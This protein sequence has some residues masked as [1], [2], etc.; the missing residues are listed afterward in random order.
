[1]EAKKCLLAAVCAGMLWCL[2]GSDQAAGGDQA[3][4]ADASSTGVGVVECKDVEIRAKI[5]GYITEINVEEGQTVAVGEPL[6]ATDPRDLEVK[7]L[8]AEASVKGAQAQLEKARNG[9]RSQEV[10]A[11]KA[12]ADK[13]QANVDLLQTQYDKMQQMYEAG[14][15]SP[16]TMDQLTTQLEAAKL[17]LEAA[18][19]Q[20]NMA[21]AGARQEDI[22]AL[23]AQ[24]EAAQ[25]TLAEVQLNLDETRVTAPAAGT[26]TMISS[27]V[28]ELI[29]SGTPV[30]TLTDYSDSWVT[31]NVSELQIAQVQLN[32]TVTI[33]SKA[34][35][36]Q[37]FTG[38]VVNVNKNPDFATKK[39]TNELNDQD[40]VSYEVKVKLP[41]DTATLYPGMLVDVTFPKA[42]E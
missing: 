10:D 7:K 24:Y 35:P 31:V 2:W 20:Y 18:S 21:A 15:L 36:D 34:Y 42:G 12:L 14:A 22:K 6:F 33:Q 30:V 4:T 3:A 23:E 17:D 19:Q 1:M 9:A 27:E 41:P 5:P 16:D 32:Q 39:S 25:G 26:V 37:T 8:Q 11:A 29:G 13:A 38:T 40:V 28:G